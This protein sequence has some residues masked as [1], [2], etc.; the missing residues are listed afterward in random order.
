M[1]SA[2]VITLHEK[3][4]KKHDDCNKHVI[5][6]CLTSVLRDIIIT[7]YKRYFKI[8]RQKQNSSPHNAAGT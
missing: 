6:M 1:L 7:S 3:N 2:H 8:S 5:C 4:I